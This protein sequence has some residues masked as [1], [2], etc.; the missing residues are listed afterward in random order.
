MWAVSSETR[1]SSILFLKVQ[2]K[3]TAVHNKQS[4]T[5]NGR[6]KLGKTKDY[7]TPCS[8]CWRSWAAANRCVFGRYQIGWLRMSRSSS[9]IVS[10]RPS[11]SVSS[12]PAG[13]VDSGGGGGAGGG[14]VGG[15]GGGTRSGQD[16]WRDAGV[17]LTL[18]SFRIESRSEAKLFNICEE[19]NRS[20]SMTDRLQWLQR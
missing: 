6:E 16:E 18:R 12:T 9:E 11:A 17:G 20:K 10:A 13:D 3:K 8:W 2:N 15:G 4:S 5:K 7:R 19:K 14:G 1:E